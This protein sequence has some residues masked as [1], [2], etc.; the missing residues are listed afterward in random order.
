MTPLHCENEAAGTLRDNGTVR[1]YSLQ[2]YVGAIR[3]TA[4]YYFAGVGF[5][6]YEWATAAFR[7]SMDG[8]C[9]MVCIPTITD[10]LVLQ[11]ACL[12]EGMWKSN[13]GGL[14]YSFQK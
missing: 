2:Q 5:I 6:P 7:L 9:R 12:H 10:M 13:A 3:E 4:E 11:T 14:R 8:I 1:Q